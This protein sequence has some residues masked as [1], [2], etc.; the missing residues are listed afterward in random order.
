MSCSCV[1]TRRRV[2]HVMLQQ[3]STE[4]GIACIGMLISCKH[5]RLSLGFLRNALPTGR[6]GLSASSL[7]GGAR[8]LGL[9]LAPL[10]SSLGELRLFD[11]P[12]ILHWGFVH[13][14]VLESWNGSVGRIVDPALGRRTV[15]REEFIDRFTGVVLQPVDLSVPKDVDKRI[16]L[17]RGSIAGFQS[18]VVRLLVDSFKCNW[19]RF[20]VAL[21]AYLL[22]AFVPLVAST[23]TAVVLDVGTQ[24]FDWHLG[25]VLVLSFGL[26]VL[27]ISLARSFSSG[28]L[29]VNLR[30]SLTIPTI[31]KLMRAPLSYFRMR[32]SGDL[33]ERVNGLRSIQGLIGSLFFG[34]L[35]DAI[36]LVVYSVLIFLVSVPIGIFV[37]VCV[38]A[39]LILVGFIGRGLYSRS[40]NVAQTDADQQSF[41]IQ[42]ISSI[43]DIKNFN[44]ESSFGRKWLDRIHVSAVSEFRLIAYESIITS[45]T[46]VAS[47]CLPLG[48]LVVGINFVGNGSLSV[49]VLVGVTSLIG[50]M[51]S[52]SSN[53]GSVIQDLIS[54]QASV[55]RVADIFDDA[56]RVEGAVNGP[57]ARATHNSDIVLENVSKSYD[58]SFANA[59][60]GVSFRV[61]FG[62]HI[63]V[64]GPTGAGKTTLLRLIT[65]VEKAS[66]G[67]I[68]FDGVDSRCLNERSISGLFGVVSQ[69]GRMIAGTIRDN[70]VF[71]DRVVSDRSIWSCLAIAAIDNEVGLMPMGLDTVLGDDGVGLSGG[72]KQRIALARALLYAPSILVLDE[73][74][75]ALD[76]STEG[77]VFSNLSGL[78]L[79]VISVSHRLSIERVVDHVVDLGSDLPR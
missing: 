42:A 15:G 5:R 61:G 70:L 21:V 50:V 52:S 14:V 7:I 40:I 18:P 33:L 59:V 12:V 39:Y 63:L 60:D 69:S 72:Q 29:S 13:Y 66:S 8:S 47:V 57:L 67:R 41:G 58:G 56:F 22:A 54:A 71:G 11:R 75:S 62:E 48:V 76:A 36:G 44:A 51:L 2:S 79:T 24:D 68:W 25:V 31:A 32:S 77:V 64:K 35:L 37:S 30:M 38:I 78:D 9:Y 34:A 1:K 3:S 16:E 65:G 46:M 6:D 28:V 17:R 43:E 49:G 23:L 27:C 10:S 20:V 55:A 45:I 53:L 26:G 73:A 4:C 19:G 74:T